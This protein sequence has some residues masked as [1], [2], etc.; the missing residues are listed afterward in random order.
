MDIEQLARFLIR[1]LRKVILVSA[2]GWPGFALHNT[3]GFRIVS[4]A[5]SF[6]GAPANGGKATD[7]GPITPMPPPGIRA[8]RPLLSALAALIF[9]NMAVVIG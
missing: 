5:P 3:W 7:A 1:G 9:M 8:I 6:S 2:G 4:S